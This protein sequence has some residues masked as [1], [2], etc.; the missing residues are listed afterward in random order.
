MKYMFKTEPSSIPYKAILKAVVRE[1][2]DEDPI[3]KA[4]QRILMK[5]VGEHDFSKQD[6]HHILNG[7]DFVEFSKQII[8][9]N[10]MGATRVERLPR[11]GQ[12]QDEQDNNQSRRATTA[13]NIAGHYW[14]RDADPKYADALHRFQEHGEGTDPAQIS[15]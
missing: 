3:R 6:C 2:D 12:Q 15:L 14:E 11:E 5:T 8:P 1:T 13:T 10:V 4:F 7:L 9:V